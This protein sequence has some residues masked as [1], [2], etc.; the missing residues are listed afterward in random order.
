MFPFPS[1]HSATSQ[2]RNGPTA[3]QHAVVVEPDERT[4]QRRVALPR[5]NARVGGDDAVD[6]LRVAAGVRVLAEKTVR[7]VGSSPT[8]SSD[9]TYVTTHADVYV[10]DI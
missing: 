4:H 9:P 7:A 3:D 2:R 10:S 6:D 5:G 8:P 1:N